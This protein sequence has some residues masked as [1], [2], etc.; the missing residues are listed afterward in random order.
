M[1]VCMYV[2]MYM[3]LCMYEYIYIYIYICF[4]IEK[5][6]LDCIIEKL[7]MFYFSLAPT[8]PTT[9][10]SE[11]RILGWQ[12]DKPCSHSV[13]AGLLLHL[14]SILYRQYGAGLG[15]ALLVYMYHV[16]M[17]ASVLG[18]LS[19]IHVHTYMHNTYIHSTDPINPAHS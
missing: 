17:L 19:P 18:P 7:C 8:T 1:Y 14:C 9:G 6:E 12:T 2:C 3:Y 13:S 11:Y 5:T 4:Q 15:V 10:P 16:C